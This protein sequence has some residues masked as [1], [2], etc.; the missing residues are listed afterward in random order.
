WQ[1]SGLTWSGMVMSSR[2]SASGARS[3]RPPDR[4]GR[5][6]GL[7][8]MAAGGLAVTTISPATRPVCVLTARYTHLRL[9]DL[10]DAAE[11][12]PRL[13]PGRP[14]DGSEVAELRATGADGRG[15]VA[16]SKAS[17]EDDPVCPRSVRPA[18]SG[19]SSLSLVG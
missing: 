6:S 4:V 7:R 3:P 16:S 11:K 8:E 5:A 14:G 2:R 1:G 17:D 19:S 12:L 18:V 9:N 15:P 13:L 10:A